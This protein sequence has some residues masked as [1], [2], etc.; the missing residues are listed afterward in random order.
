MKAQLQAQS[1]SISPP[2]ESGMSR[3]TAAYED[4]DPSRLEEVHFDQ[5]SCK[6][7]QSKLIIKVMTTCLKPGVNEE[8]AT[9]TC[10]SPS[11]DKVCMIKDQSDTRASIAHTFPKLK[12]RKD[13]TY[14][15]NHIALLQVSGRYPADV[16]HLSP[17]G[18]SSDLAFSVFM[19]GKPF[20]YLSS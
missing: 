16:R 3:A 19:K 1:I 2:V 13:Y 5:S 17:S 9:A 7:C 8:T 14:R 12:H 15:L 20:P 6:V 11:V 10:W 4:W 18:A